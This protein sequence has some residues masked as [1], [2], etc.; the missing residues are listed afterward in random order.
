MNETT[1]TLDEYGGQ[2]GRWAAAFAA[3][4]YQEFEGDLEAACTPHDV[5]RFLNNNFGKRCTGLIRE[6]ASLAGAFDDLPALVRAYVRTVPGAPY[7]HTGPAD[8]ERFLIWL[9]QTQPLTPVQRDFVTCQ[10][11]EYA[12]WTEA[13][14]NR[15]A[16]LRFQQLRKQA[17]ERAAQ[18]GAEPRLR[19]H[20]NPIRCA[21]ELLTSV[22]AP[23][24]KSLPA[25]A[26]FYAA[27][28]SVHGTL[29]EEA[30]AKAVCELAARG[31]CTL[32]E[33]TA[34]AGPAHRRKLVRLAGELA[35]QGLL[36]FD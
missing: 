17:G 6:T 30:P 7:D 31:P 29:L 4:R 10:R 8:E 24:V 14:R 23:G 33:W 18:L 26:L 22:L 9:T 21:G 25:E 3:G 13:R 34:G 12:I 2:L 16:H 19:I 5:R 28:T 27:G 20:L 15:P 11:G 35:A 1:T 32:D 36:A